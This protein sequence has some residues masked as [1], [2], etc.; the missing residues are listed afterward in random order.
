MV[1]PRSRSSSIESSTWSCISRSA[2]PPQSWMKQ[3]ASVDLP[4]SMCAMMEKLRIRLWAINK[5]GAPTGGTLRLDR[6]FSSALV[7]EPV[8]RDEGHRVAAPHLQRDDR[9]LVG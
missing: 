9:A 2:T 6:Y 3:S 7:G 4:W 5:E 1:M 8:H